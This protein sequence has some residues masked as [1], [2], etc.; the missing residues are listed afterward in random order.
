MTR[1]ASIILP[2]HNEAGYI[3]ACLGAVLESAPLP[4]GWRGELLVVANGCTDDTIALAQSVPRGN[5]WPV[6]VLEVPEGGKL[7]ALNRGEA[8]A[9]GEVLIY[10]DAD[11]IVSPALLPS[12]VQAL[13]V[14]APLYAGGV[15]QVA[16]ADSRVTR[17]YGRFWTRLPFTRDG[18]PG[19]GIFAMNR[20]GRN[21]WGAWPDIISDDTFAR[22]SF[23]PQERI[24]VPA[25]YTWPMVEGFTNLV[26]VRRR[27]DAGVNQIK[28]RF[29]ELLANDDKHRVSLDMLMRLFLSDPLGF[30][31]YA[32]VSVA[33][34]AG[35][36]RSQSRWARGR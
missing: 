25:D 3:E 6:R 24:G 17:A 20:A 13:D 29:P 9:R 35:L 34:W 2:A 10:L 21:R 32:A 16:P 18:V 14:P 1:I 36:F 11:V 26:R 5:D 27:Q 23:A 22:L 19:F 31:V 28:A 4:K 15:P 7:G 12:L 33:V 30:C 8:E